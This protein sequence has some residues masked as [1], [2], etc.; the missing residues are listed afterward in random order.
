MKLLVSGEGITELGRAG[1]ARDGQV[2]LIDTLVRRA[3]AD[4]GRRIVFSTHRFERV[5]PPGRRGDLPRAEQA[6]LEARRRACDGVVILRD[7][8]HRADARRSELEGACERTSLPWVVAI[9]IEAI[10]AWVMADATAVRAVLGPHV[11]P[12]PRPEHLWGSPTGRGHP[13]R[14]WEHL[15]RAAGVAPHLATKAAVLERAS[16]ETLRAQCPHG[17]ARFYDALEAAFPCFDLVVAAD[18]AWGI[19][20]E[21]GLPW[22]KLK[23][24][25]AH[26]KRIT[27][28]AA[29][30]KRNAILMGRRTWES[31]EVNRRPLPRRLSVVIS[32]QEQALPDGVVGARSLTEAAFRARQHADIDQIFV[33]G[34]AEIY[35]QA[36]AHPR[37]R[38]AYLT[39]VD[40][41]FGCDTTIPSLDDSLVPDATW[42]EGGS[43]EDNGIGYTIERLTRRPGT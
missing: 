34:G 24:D 37:L 43:F 17:F 33:V 36:L 11:S 9:A 29:P 21:Q 2:G 30:G 14:E 22:P 12:P 40:G 23:A 35:R 4:D 25:L 41:E 31:K 26:F 15:C 6:L 1:S 5:G 28:D 10:E 7:A 8:D 20:A 32:R 19:G 39:R 16:L 3:L 13:A 38:F 27:S 18:R 42:R